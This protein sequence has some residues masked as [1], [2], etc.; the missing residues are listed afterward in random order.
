MYAS[1]AF[2]VS[3]AGI[4]DRR[5]DR[6]ADLAKPRQAG[7]ADELTA[8]APEGIDGAAVSNVDLGALAVQLRLGDVARF[9][10]AA[11]VFQAG[12]EHW[13]DERHEFMIATLPSRRRI[14]WTNSAPFFPA[15]HSRLVHSDAVTM[16]HHCSR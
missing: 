16:C 5:G 7:Q 2:G 1:P 15:I 8:G 11:W 4:E 6:P 9:G 14:P 13:G 3:T 12:G 10:E